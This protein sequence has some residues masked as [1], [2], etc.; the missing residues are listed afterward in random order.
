MIGKCGYRY[1]D[2]EIEVDLK[3]LTVILGDNNVH[4]DFLFNFLSSTI[5]THR[6]YWENERVLRGFISDRFVNLGEFVYNDKEGVK[7]DERSL[8]SCHFYNPS[9][10]FSPK[11]ISEE[12]RI[13]L[14]QHRFEFILDRVDC[15]LDPNTSIE[16]AKVIGERVRLGEGHFLVRTF[17]PYFLNYLN[18]L[19]YKGVLNRNTLSVYKIRND[20]VVY[21]LMSVNVEFID[22][23]YLSEPINEIYEEYRLLE[24]ELKR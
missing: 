14:E 3:P 12:R 13:K 8:L 7:K 20:G 6:T 10:S 23:M 22:V 16:L 24:R 1:L 4:T 11:C 19:L 21:S 9:R 5:K 17:N 15:C 18:V 2:N